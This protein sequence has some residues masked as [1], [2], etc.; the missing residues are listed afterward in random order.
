MRDPVKQDGFAG[1]QRR[2]ARHRHA[3][4]IDG[5][6]IRR[7]AEA[8]S[9]FP[10][11]DALDRR[12]H[13]Q[14]DGGEPEVCHTLHKRHDCLTLSRPVELKPGAART[15]G[16]DGTRLDAALRA[17]CHDGILR[18]GAER[19]GGFPFGVNQLLVGDWREHD[20]VRHGLIKQRRPGRAATDIAQHARKQFD[21]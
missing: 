16:A 19:H 2:K 4:K 17:Q 15:G 5:G 18:G 3:G 13:R 7:K 9:C 20:R 14:H 21:I 1:L 8:G 10:I 6:D 12:V 11:A